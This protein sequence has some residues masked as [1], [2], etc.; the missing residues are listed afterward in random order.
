MTDLGDK[1]RAK[2]VENKTLATE[3]LR[4]TNVYNFATTKWA[5]YQHKIWPP[6][7]HK[8]FAVRAHIEMPAHMHIIF[9]CVC[10]CQFDLRLRIPK[11][12]PRGHTKSICA[13][14]Q[15]L[16]NSMIPRMRLKT[17]QR[18][19]TYAHS[20]LP[21]PCANQAEQHCARMRIPKYLAHAQT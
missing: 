16:N 20:E 2:I 12:Y 14:V 15:K 18:V 11:S 5:A 7:G 9:V 13:C 1:Y 19:R 10:A 17:R 8:N 6:N 3:T 4:I 21:R